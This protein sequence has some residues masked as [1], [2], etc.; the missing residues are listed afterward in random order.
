MK[1]VGAINKE[2]YNQLSMK[3]VFVSSLYM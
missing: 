2:Q 3:C 1:H